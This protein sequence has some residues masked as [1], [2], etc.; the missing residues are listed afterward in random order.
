MSIKRIKTIFNVPNR[1]KSIYNKKIFYFSSNRPVKAPS[2]Y[3][4]IT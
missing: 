4:R 3:S 1:E 2:F